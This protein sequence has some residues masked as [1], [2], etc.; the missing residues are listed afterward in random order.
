MSNI[1]KQTHDGNGNDDKGQPPKKVARTKNMGGKDGPKVKD[2]LGYLKKVQNRFQNEPAVYN[3][4]LEIMKEFKSQAIDTEGVIKR[5][6]TLF[7]GNRNLIL[8]FN[9][10]LPPGYRIEVEKPMLEFD[11]AVQ[12]VAKIKERFRD[13]PKTYAEFLDIL[14]EYQSKCTID[15]VYARV[16]KL[17]KDDED[18]LKEFQY[19]LPEGNGSL[20]P[21][22]GA[23][24]LGGWGG[25]KKGKKGM[26][27]GN[28]Q[29]SRPAQSRAKAGKNLTARKSSYNQ[30]RN[31]KGNSSLL[32]SYIY[33]PLLSP[34]MYVFNITFFC[35]S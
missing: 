13:C 9:Q 7:K 3:Q 4:F 35:K 23:G 12:Y 8:G 2:A 26:A 34:S 6:K 33:F 18:L 14:H 25:A 19:F 1:R 11:Y 28:L 27:G 15:E 17:F 24:A 10:F 29:V 21:P 32:P 16:Q 31:G 20:M 5:V 30:A 22:A